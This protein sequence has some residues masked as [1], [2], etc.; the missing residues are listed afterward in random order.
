MLSKPAQQHF[1]DWGYRPVNA[2]VLRR[3]QEQV[4]GPA[5]ALHDRHARRLERVND[6]FFDVEH[7]AIAKLEESAG[8]STAK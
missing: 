4:P 1:A 8:V 7:G 3:E 6:Q 2:D 5:R